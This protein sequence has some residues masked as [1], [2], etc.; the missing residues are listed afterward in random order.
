MTTEYPSD[1][2][3]T[4]AIKG[5]L[6]KAF[7]T[8]GISITLRRI[9]HRMDRRQPETVEQ[10]FRV[11]AIIGHELWPNTSNWRRRNERRPASSEGKSR[12]T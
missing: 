10:D 12:G 7:P 5:A 3:A 4:R 6:R 9:A 1:G 2:E 8:A 11:I